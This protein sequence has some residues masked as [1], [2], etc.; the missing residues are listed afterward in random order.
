MH[1]TDAEILAWLGDWMWPFIRVSGFLLTAPIISTRTVPARVRA[2]LAIALSVVLVP[3]AA[4]GR[5]I[6]PLDA[7]GLLTA[8]QQLVIGAAI[9]L[10]L[11]L[12]FF[13]FEFAGQLVAQQTGLGFASMVDPTSGAQMPLVA[14]FYVILATLLFFAVDA[15]LLL[16]ELLA[17]SFRLLP[18]GP[19]GITAAG[20]EVVMA[21]SADLVAAGLLLGLPVVVALLA[22]NFALG[23]MARAAP[24]LNIFAVG[25]PVMILFGMV[26]IALTLNNFSVAVI[27]HFDGG[28]DMAR[29][30]LGA[31]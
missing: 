29:R 24:Q 17:D 22:I 21:W 28:F 19:A 25:F 15:H 4:P 9:G 16:I 30:M 27:G 8:M 3:V 7:E 18:V 20:A 1:F 5:V 23:V 14:H 2:V 12:V 6:D 26:L 10:V 11:R 13:V 31:Q